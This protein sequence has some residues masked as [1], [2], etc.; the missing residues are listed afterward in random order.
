[1]VNRF[2]HKGGFA[3]MAATDRKLTKTVPEK[4]DEIID[5]KSIK[6]I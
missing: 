3:D 4:I 5:R 1:M 6:N 2:D